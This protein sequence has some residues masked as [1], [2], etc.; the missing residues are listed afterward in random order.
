V[1]APPEQ[2]ANRPIGQEHYS[3][4]IKVH[5]AAARPRKVQDPRPEAPVGGPAQSTGT[6]S[7]ELGPVSQE[8]VTEGSQWSSVITLCYGPGGPAGALAAADIAK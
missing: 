3:V 5:V 2:G 6:T 4:L 8:F 1:A 7:E